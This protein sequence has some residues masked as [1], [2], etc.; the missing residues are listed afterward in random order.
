[1]TTFGRDPFTIRLQEIYSMPDGPEKQEAFKQLFL[2]YPG[3]AEQFQSMRDTGSEQMF[4][5]GPEGGVAG[6]YSNPF[7][8]YVG[9]GPTKQV[10]HAMR[11]HQGGEDFRAG[12]AGLEK[13]SQMSEQ[14]RHDT[15]T[16]PMRQQQAQAGI[17]R[18]PT[19][20]MTPEQRRIKE[21]EERLRRA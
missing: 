10:A 17:L 16:S 8:R 21:E 14:A 6:P 19:Y 3:R 12:R 9:A 11:V 15:Y 1:M 18:D 5:K 13:L 7:S 2:D 20:Y 4:A